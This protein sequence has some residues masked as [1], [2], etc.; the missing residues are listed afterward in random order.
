MHKTDAGEKRNAL[1]REGLELARGAKAAMKAAK[2]LARPG[3]DQKY[4]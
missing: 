1:Q 3:E 2:V 4:T